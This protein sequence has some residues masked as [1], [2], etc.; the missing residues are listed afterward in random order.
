MNY[1][2]QLSWGGGQGAWWDSVLWCKRA[3]LGSLP[4]CLVTQEALC[5]V[6]G[7]LRKIALVTC[8]ASRTLVGNLVLGVLQG[9]AAK[10][11]AV[12]CHLCVGRLGWMQGM[13]QEGGVTGERVHPCSPPVRNR[14]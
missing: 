8:M 10:L 5:P 6:W 9:Q 13:A 2:G 11:P 4:L 12:D 3:W 14:N 1:P 7:C